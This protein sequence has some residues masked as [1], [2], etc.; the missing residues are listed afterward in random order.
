MD[1]KNSMKRL[2][3]H[4]QAAILAGRLPGGQKLPSTRILADELQISRNT[5][6]NAYEQLAAEGYIHTNHSLWRKR[7]HG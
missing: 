2:F 7:R 1:D 5:V 6:L 4:L 3:I